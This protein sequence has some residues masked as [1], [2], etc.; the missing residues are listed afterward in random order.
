MKTITAFIFAI[1]VFVSTANAATPSGSAANAASVPTAASSASG[2]AVSATTLLPARVMKAAHNRVAAGE[3]PMLVI[4]VVNGGKSRLY[5]FN[6]AGDPTPNADTVFEIGSVTKTFTGLLLAEAVKAGAVALDEP[7]AK[8]LPKFKI[9]SRNGKLVTLGNLADQHSGL[10]R[11]PGNLA[12]ADPNNPY[13]GYDAKRLKTFLAGY[14]LPRDPGSAYEYSNLG[15]GLLGYALAQ[16]AG[17]SYAGLVKKEILDPLHL[18]LCGVSLDKLLREHLAAGH[19]ES[20]KKTENWDLAVLAGAGGLKCSAADMMR[21]LKANMVAASGSKNVVSSTSAASSSSRGAA[22]AGSAQASASVLRP[23]RSKLG[24][25]TESSLASAMRLAHRPRADGPGKNR[26]GL[27]W[28]TLVTNDATIVWHNGM[29][30]G[31]ASFIGFSADGKRGVFVLTNI[32]QSVDDLGFATLLKS[33]S[34]EPVQT[35]I[36]MSPGALDAY[37]GYYQM[38][39]HFLLNVFRN[40]DQLYAQATGQGALPIYPSAKD[41]FFAK[42]DDIAI[43]FLRGHGNKIVGLMLHQHGDVPAKRVDAADAAQ[44]IGETLVPLKAA[45]LRDYVG[46]YKFSSGSAMEITHRHGHLYAQL[47]GQPALPIY[48]SAKDQFFYIL[49]KARISFERGKNGA[50]DALVLHQGGANQKAV[51]AK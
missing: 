14:K 13:A 48:P 46:R 9:P 11:L 37:V 22:S 45:T 47:G 28:M 51:K 39:P 44:A 4:G 42:A 10:P 20:G 18:G 49:V 31:Y 6:A 38:A 15:F 32:Q 21:Y 27:G 25:S 30:G 41:E 40:D 8:L 35:T 1:F 19:D 23:A 36:Q 3:Y 7:V 50:V 17:V 26:A 12:P 2:A 5:G 33:A 43:S 16:H 34:L 24:L 29:T